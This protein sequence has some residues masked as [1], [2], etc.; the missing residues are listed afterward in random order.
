MNIRDYL[1]PLTVSNLG[2]SFSHGAVTSFLARSAKLPTG[3]YILLVLISFFFLFL[4][5]LSERAKKI[6]LFPRPI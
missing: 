4:L 2:D 6:G 5:A 3:L 1:L